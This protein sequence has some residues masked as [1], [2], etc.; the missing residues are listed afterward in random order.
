MVSPSKD[1]TGSMPQSTTG[2]VPRI[3]GS[4]NLVR[5]NFPTNTTKHWQAIFF[6][7]RNACLHMIPSESN[8]NPFITRILPTLLPVKMEQHQG[9]WHLLP[10][11]WSLPLHS[12]G[13]T[14]VL[15][16]PLGSDLQ[17]GPGGGSWNPDT[18]ELW[19][20]GHGKQMDTTV[21]TLKPLNRILERLQSKVSLRFNSRIVS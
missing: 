20:N 4:A 21:I 5:D 18:K 13:Q 2:L 3:Q 17:P 9:R 12:R 10:L 1:R 16:F 15:C 7:T 8:L 6:F 19:R 14:Q 11:R